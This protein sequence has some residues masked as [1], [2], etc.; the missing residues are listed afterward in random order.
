MSREKINVVFLDFDGVL[1]TERSNFQD[2][3]INHDAVNNFN[4]LCLENDLKVVISSSWR[5]Y[6]G[7]IDLFYSFGI[8]KHIDIIGAI[9]I[10]GN[11][12]AFLIKEYIKAHPEINKYIILDDVYL[13]GELNSHLVQTTY[14]MGFNERK[15]KEAVNKLYEDDEKEEEKKKEK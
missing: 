12:K 2:E 13:G 7:Y 1:S 6:D 8:D 3:I 4:T 10:T 15:L 11:G 5:K 9:P 14:S